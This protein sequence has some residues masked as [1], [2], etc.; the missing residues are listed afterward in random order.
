LLALVALVGFAQAASSFYSNTGTRDPLVLSG[1]PFAV[2]VMDVKLEPGDTMYSRPIDIMKLPINYRDTGTGDAA[3]VPDLGAGNAIVSCYDIYDTT[4][5]DSVDVTGQFYVSQYAGNN[6]DPY[7]SGERGGK[8]DAWATLG[9]AYSL[10]AASASSA[11]VEATAAV[12]LGSQLDR[13]VRVRLINDNDDGTSKDEARC[14]V[15]WTAKDQR[16]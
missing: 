3:L 6:S 4:G 9:S 14:R 8:N 2:L 10:D 16:R 13:F 12:T 15:Y 11:I 7:Q 5:T 1:P